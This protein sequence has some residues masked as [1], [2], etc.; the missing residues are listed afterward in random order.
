M[1]DSKFKLERVQGAPV[2]DQEL[3]A[4]MQRAA[5]LAGADVLSQR[6]YTEFGQY[7]PRTASRRFGSW[8][9]AVVAAGLQIANEIN[10][11]DD[12][13][14][15]NIMLLWEHYGR[16]PR[17][18]ELASP[19]SR[20]SCGA[21]RRRFASWMDA[22]TQFVAYANAQDARPP[23]Q[24]EA[25]TGHRTSRD[26]SLRMRFRVLKRDN[27]SCRACGATPA[28]TPGLSLHVDHINAWS[29]GGETIDDNLQTLCEPCN[30][31]KS[32]A[33]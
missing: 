25:R 5:Q 19:P 18:A 15:E 1:N 13:L 27:F 6:L 33:L 8:N 3:L 23:D 28:L 22:L 16:Q 21:Y 12:R 10:I 11:S 4:D 30:L 26:P 24:M 17:R 32:N 31:G 14:F 7:D 9:K 2:S 20:I 29:L